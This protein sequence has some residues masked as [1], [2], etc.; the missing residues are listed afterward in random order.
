MRTIKKNW[1][2]RPVNW[3]VFEALKRLPHLDA[4]G[5]LEDD[6]KR[7]AKKVRSEGEC[8]M[9]ISSVVGFRPGRQDQGYGGFHFLGKRMRSHR[10]TYLLLNREIPNGREL[11]HLCR[12]P[13][14]CNPRHMDLVTH[15]ENC[16]RGESPTAINAAKEHCANG[17]KYDYVSPTGRRKCRACNADR[18]RKS[19]AAKLRAAAKEGVE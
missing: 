14:C 4:M 7:F 16:L 5:V 15:K 19:Y 18:M 2:K 11:D 1:D 12:K 9:W 17:H 13:R 3:E 8:W 6:L 10:F